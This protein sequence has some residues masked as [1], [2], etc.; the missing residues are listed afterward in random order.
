MIRKVEFKIV[1]LISV[2]I[3]AETEYEAVGIAQLKLMK[4]IPENPIYDG[5]NI[6]GVIEFAH[7]PVGV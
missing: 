5:V 1:C 2:E 4:C 7:Q 3:E 6:K